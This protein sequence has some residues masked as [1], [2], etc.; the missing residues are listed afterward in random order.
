[1]HLPKPGQISAEELRGLPEGA[2]VVTYGVA[3]AKIGPDLWKTP[4][5]MHVPVRDIGQPNLR[6]WEDE[7]NSEWL[8]PVVTLIVFNP[9]EWEGL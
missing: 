9:A 3:W 4:F 8:A 6:R 5:T 1:M 2:V 7:A